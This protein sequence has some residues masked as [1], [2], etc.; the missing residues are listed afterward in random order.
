M[1][2]L[3][4]KGY[5]QMINLIA[6]SVAQTTQS[7]ILIVAEHNRCDRTILDRILGRSIKFEL[8]GDSMRKVKKMIDA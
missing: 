4:N 2:Q 6:S 7:A 8:K 3:K 1:K 5:R